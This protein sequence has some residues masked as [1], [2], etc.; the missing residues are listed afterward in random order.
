MKRFFASAAAFAI[1]L[2]MF[3]CAPDEKNDSGIAFESETLTITVGET[4]EVKAV[5]AGGWTDK[6]VEWS[7]SDGNVVSL[8]VPSKNIQPEKAR[9]KA[10]AAGETSVTAKA[11][12]G[13]TATINVTV[14]DKTSGGDGQEP[15]PDDPDPESGKLALA[16]DCLNVRL[17]DSV[18]FPAEN[19]IGAQ[20]SS[21]D[22]DVASVS[23]DGVVTGVSEG[24]TYITAVKDGVSVTVKT[25]VAAGGEAEITFTAAADPRV[26]VYGR[27][28]F[29][30]SLGAQMLYFSASGF[31]VCFYGTELKAVMTRE[32]TDTYVPYLSVFADGEK[33]TDPVPLNS[34]RVIKLTETSAKEYTLASGLKNGWHTVKVRKRTAFQRGAQKMDT[35]GVKRLASDGC[36]GYAPDKPSLRIDVYGDS[37]SCGYGNLEDGSSMTSENTDANQAYHALLAN[38]IGAELNVAAASG[39]GVYKGNSGLADWS[40]AKFYD[41]LNPQSSE[42]YDVSGADVILINLGANDVSGG[43]FSSADE[44]QKFKSAY[45]EWLSKLR[46]ANPQAFILCTYGFGGANAAC[47]DAIKEVADGMDDA[48]IK[49]YF[50]TTVQAPTGHPDVANHAKGASELETLFKLLQII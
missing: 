39:W 44:T 24:V 6:N 9:L 15:D 19:A 18:A 33:L 40:W 1:C 28:K 36:I 7:V 26:A 4:K 48:K 5:F 12:D 25:G 32:G 17:G 29:D 22:A 41:K 27:T 21:E 11:S 23:S 38:K 43:A 34:G 47:K 3:A 10:L 31:D 8:T 30:T 35:V 37:Y 46:A 49:A 13:K 42:P 16:A 20:F 45:S 2:T 50:Y 14:S